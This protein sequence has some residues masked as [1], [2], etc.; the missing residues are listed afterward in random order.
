VSRNDFVLL[1]DFRSSLRRLS[2]GARLH[3][4][5]RRVTEIIE[6]LGQH[7]IAYLLCQFVGGGTRN[8][9]QQQLM[10][11]ENELRRIRCLINYHLLE[12]LAQAGSVV[13]KTDDLTEIKLLTH[14]S[15]PF[16]DG[17]YQQYEKA[18]ERC[19]SEIRA[20]SNYLIKEEPLSVTHTARMDL[21]SW[22]ACEDNHV[23]IRDQVRPLST[24]LRSK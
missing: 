13:S 22:F 19:P 20:F 18:V 7:L 5:D 23:Y 2:N 21:D 10:D 4:R 15:G 24:V 6:T 16:T 3:L 8:Y 9:T 17:D 11:V 1:D 14:K 12:K